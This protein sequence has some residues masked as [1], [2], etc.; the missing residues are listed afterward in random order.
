MSSQRSDVG[1]VGGSGGS[2]PYLS[3]VLSAIPASKSVR[4]ELQRG[5]NDHVVTYAA[6]VLYPRLL[7]LILGN[8]NTMVVVVNQVEPKISFALILSPLTRVERKVRRTT[9]H[10]IACNFN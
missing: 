7:L 1:G 2:R 9:H 10:G 8:I 4:V 3:S 6:T 5:L